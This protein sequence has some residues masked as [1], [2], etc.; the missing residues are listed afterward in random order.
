MI[1]RDAHAIRMPQRLVNCA[2]AQ[3]TDPAVTVKDLAT[4]ET[5]LYGRPSF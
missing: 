5:W 1:Q 3:I 2:A 4:C